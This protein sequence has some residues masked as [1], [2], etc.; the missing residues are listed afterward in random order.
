MPPPVG[1]DESK[2]ATLAPSV[3][4]GQTNF[5]IWIE[6]LS[7]GGGTGRSTMVSVVVLPGRTVTASRGATTSKPGGAIVSTTR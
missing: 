4:A 7:G 3:P 1:S 2:N 6:P 5:L